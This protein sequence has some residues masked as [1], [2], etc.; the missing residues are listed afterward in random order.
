MRKIGINMRSVVDIPDEEYIKI[1]SQ[2]GFSAT[3]TD[4]LPE[5][6]HLKLA[7]ILARYGV[8]YETLHAPFGHINDIWFDTDEGIQMESELRD[9]INK[10][11]LAGVP[12][13]VM[14]LSSGA[15]PP[16]VTDIGR[17]RFE[18]IIEYAQKKNV[19]IAFENQRKL[20]NISW[21]LEYHGADQNVGF[22][23]DCGHESCFT[24][25]R[26]YMPLFGDGLVCLHIHDNSGIYNRDDHML[27]FDGKVNFD[28]FA[29][30]I[31][32]YNYTGTLMLE[33]FKGKSSAYTSLTSEEYLQKAFEAADKLRKIV[34]KIY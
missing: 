16:D 15:T 14:H 29:D 34:D 1:I 11:A 9:C 12:V 4:T 30:Y 23:W 31:G 32:K 22:C 18:N 3:F 13:A 28:V 5:K 25:G 26:V 17:K 7:D 2:L 27:P 33:V 24:P 21:A 19:C 10:C 20:A 8:A 6:E